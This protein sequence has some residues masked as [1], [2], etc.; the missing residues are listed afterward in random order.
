MVWEMLYHGRPNVLL[1]GGSLSG[2]L[3]HWRWSLPL[4]VWRFEPWNPY[5]WREVRKAGSSHTFH[6]YIWPI[7]LSIQ[8]WQLDSWEKDLL[9]Q[10]VACD[11]GTGVI[12]ESFHV[13]DPT[14]Y[15]VN[16]SRANMSPASWSL[17]SWYRYT[18]NQ[19]KP[20]LVCCLARIYVTDFS[21]HLQPLKQCFGSNLGG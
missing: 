5:L 6:R 19:I 16:G 13:D 4:L 20:M 11:G 2:L 12:T 17:L 3:C 14:K 8:G 9:D 1:V 10:L 21:S 15:C 18:E 7:A